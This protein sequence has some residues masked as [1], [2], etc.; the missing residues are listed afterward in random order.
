MATQTN[1]GMAVDVAQASGKRPEAVSL[2]PGELRITRV[3]CLYPEPDSLCLGTTEN[4]CS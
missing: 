1:S 3:R 4:H 2:S